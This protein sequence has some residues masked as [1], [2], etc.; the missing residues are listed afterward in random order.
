MSDTETNRAWCIECPH[1]YHKHRYVCYYDHDEHKHEAECVECRKLFV[2]WTES[3]THYH[4]D[5]IKAS[6][7]GE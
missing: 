5:I 6:E 2:Y 7:S 1:C 3:V 4:A